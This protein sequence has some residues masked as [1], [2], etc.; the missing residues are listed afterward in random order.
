MDINF[1]SKMYYYQV[2]VILTSPK[3][4]ESTRKLMTRLTFM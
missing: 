2:V 4:P 1:F 3:Y